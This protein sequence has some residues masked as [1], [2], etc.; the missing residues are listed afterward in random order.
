MLSD[1]TFFWVNVSVLSTK[2]ASTMACSSMDA[3]SEE[4]G[5]AVSGSKKGV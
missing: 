5:L 2:M 3:P 1:A 4:R